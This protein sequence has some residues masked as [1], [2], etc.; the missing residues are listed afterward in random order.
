MIKSTNDIR[1]MF[2]DYFDNKEHKI[3]ASSS[4]IPNNDPTLL[5]T[6]AGMNQFKNIFL[7]Q[8][9]RDYM[10]AVTCQ[11]CIRAGGK[12]N[13][14]ENVGYTARHN[15]FFEMLGNF[16][17]GD[18]FKKEAILFAWE[19]LTH[20][21]W[22]NIPKNRLFIT[23]YK[24][25]NE[26]YDIWTNKIGIPHNHIIRVGD[27]KG[28]PY[29]S[30]NFWQMGDTGPCGPCCEIL[31]NYGDYN[32]N[33]DVNKSIL[34]TDNYLELWNIVFLQFDRQLDGTMLPLLKPSIDTGMGLER[35]ASVLQNVKSN[36]EIDFFK[37]LIQ[38]IAKFIGTTDLNNNSLK[39]IADHI[40]SSSFLI[41]DGVFPSNENRGY[42]LR[43]IIRR[44][45]RHGNMLGAK[46]GFFHSLVKPFLEIVWEERGVEDL[47][48][49]QVQIENILKFEEEQFD[50]TLKRG[51]S[52]LDT[53]LS[54]L[55]GKTLNG[56][57]I[58]RLH[59]TFGF[60][61]DLTKDIC[62]ERNIE[63]DSTGFEKEMMLQQIRARELNQFN[64]NDNNIICSKIESHFE[65]Y[66]QLSSLAIIKLI[67][68][69]DQK[70]ENISVIG[71]NA[72]IILDKTTFYGESGGQIGD[73]GLL[74]KCNTEFIVK[75]TKRYGNTIC[76]IGTLI[77]GKLSIG[78]SCT[79]EVNEAHRTLISL[80]HSATHLLHAA[81]CQI[82][83][84]HILQK[85]SL[86]ND[87]YL[88]FD[89]SHY[90]ALKLEEINKIEEIVNEQIFCN[91]PIET[92]IMHIEDEKLQGAKML[93][94]D[95]YD[96]HVRV[97]NIERVSFELCGG[98][99]ASR[100]GEIGLFLIKSEYGIASGIRRIEV[101]TGKNA[102]IHINEQKHKLWIISNLMKTNISNVHKKI[103][104]L[105][106]HVNVLEKELKQLR[107]KQADNES[108]LLIKKTIE[109][110]GIKLLISKINNVNSSGLHN[111]VVKLKHKL[112]SSVI[113]LA[114]IIED[115]ILLIASVTKDL[116][117]RISA[118]ELI[119]DLA[120]QIDG[121]GGGKPNLARAAGNNIKELET[122]LLSIQ[123]WVYNRL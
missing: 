122:T 31:Y 100:T 42:V 66:E 70:V 73:I 48:N 85:G 98:T 26:T 117:D 34:K 77:S 22:F 6:N 121:K 47:I 63:I 82:L 86:I 108:N 24:T 114:T 3:V 88:R 101:N 11:R 49:Q 102:L 29:C 41:A 55:K 113:V 84:D 51:L 72:L 103:N 46:K 75:D 33:N 43:R 94:K 14:L 1:Q 76:H 32:S 39:V 104:D 119:N 116:T 106:N 9:Q 57:T 58:F 59:D 78:D 97:V 19:L 27:Q 44:A 91:L 53:E 21:N 5:F 25:D 120:K 20:S 30:D 40:R 16:S 67:Y 69:L 15:T 99:H 56:Q 112:S 118:N 50:K 90:N 105:V 96:Q 87:K 109:I 62:R 123:S 13:D 2:I 89:F 17:F 83:G 38:V 54:K 68:V 81:L 61:I 95:K 10:R 7:C 52:L 18:Y 71:Q 74:K 4:L 12:H 45:I 35:I 115:K 28:I 65:G 36:Y 79:T 37:K 93:F 60:P 111:I 110:K 80:N 23:I 64:S 107:D 8:E 92:K